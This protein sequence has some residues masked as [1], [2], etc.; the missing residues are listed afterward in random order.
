M[1]ENNNQFDPTAFIQSQAEQ[2]KQA[3]QTPVPEAPVAVAPVSGNP[4]AQYFRQPK[5]HV[6]FPSEG[7]FWPVGSLE[8][9]QTGEHPVFAMTARDEL[10]FKTPDALMNGSAIV[11]VIQSCIPSIKNAWQMPSMD[12]DAV[13]T[14]IRMATYGVDM[15]VTAVCPK[16]E[17]SN[18][19]SVDLRNVLDNLK[20]IEFTTTVEINSDMVVHLRPMTYQEITGTALKTFE[21]QRI[22]SI[23]NDENLKEDEKLRLFNESFIKLTD[24]TLDT[25]VK[26][27]TKIESAAGTTDNPEYIKE[28][29]QKADKNVFT[30]IN[31][32]VGKSQNSGKMASFH[33]KCD[34]EECGHEWDV[35]L[36]LDQADFFGQGF[37]S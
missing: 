14:A 31:D 13:L 16:C 3:G 30:T 12:V 37:R 23:I 24:L 22:F 11:E 1:A 27:V 29:L 4:L 35:K 9:P 26:C 20:G 28:F 5:I 36:T 10:L 8:T 15:D 7:K 21:H 17:T 6:K 25:A 34:N 2:A 32:A 18:D 19:K 33:T